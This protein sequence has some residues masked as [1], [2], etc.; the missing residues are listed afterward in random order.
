MSDPNLDE[1]TDDLSMGAAQV[2]GPLGADGA[3]DES[4]QDPDVEQPI[5][6]DSGQPV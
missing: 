1:P 6:P 2:G 3:D 4:M 5:D